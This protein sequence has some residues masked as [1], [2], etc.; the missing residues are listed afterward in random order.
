[1]PVAFLPDTVQQNY[2]LSFTPITLLI[3]NNGRVENVWPGLWNRET[4]AAA[5]SSLGLQ[6]SKRDDQETAN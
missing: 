6:L 4:A 2:K 1:M 5:S 3:D